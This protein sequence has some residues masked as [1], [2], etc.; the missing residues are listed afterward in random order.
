MGNNMEYF[1]I[2][3]PLIGHWLWNTIR[4]RHK[5]VNTT[6]QYVQSLM[7]TNKPLLIFRFHSLCLRFF[8][9]VFFFYFL[10]LQTLFIK[11]TQN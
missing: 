6:M 1:R 2:E 5:I 9:V 4:R 7:T 10:C 8:W 11:Q 3:N